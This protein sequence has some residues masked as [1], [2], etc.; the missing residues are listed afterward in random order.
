MVNLDPF[1]TQEATLSLDLAALGFGA[2]QPLDVHDE[3]T[4]QDF[5]WTG[6]HP[7]VRLDPHQ[8]PG[9]VLAVGA[10]P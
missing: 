3:L 4:G 9:H 8:Q 6:P 1:A 7:Y 5:H 2:S 10:R